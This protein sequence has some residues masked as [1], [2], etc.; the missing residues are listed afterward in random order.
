MSMERYVAC[1]SDLEK[2]QLV[3]DYEAWARVGHVDDCL[4]RQHA[5]T[6]MQ[7]KQIPGKTITMY[8]TELANEVF[9]YFAYRYLE[10]LD[11]GK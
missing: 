9:R 3:K 7:V 8:M 5:T 4:L 10:T 1:M 11:D 6:L 2:Q